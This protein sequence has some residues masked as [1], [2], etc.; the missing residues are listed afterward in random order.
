MDSSKFLISYQ[1]KLQVI[2]K[3]SWGD[4]KKDLKPAFTPNVLGTT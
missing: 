4:Y 3:N 2:H 1:N